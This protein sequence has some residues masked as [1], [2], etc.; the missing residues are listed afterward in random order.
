M[1]KYL[2]IVGIIISVVV[3]YFVF[4]EEEEIEQE[5]VINEQIEEP[6]IIIN[7]VDIK[8]A[9]NKPGVYCVEEDKRVVDVIE[10]AEGLKSTA[11]TSVINLSKK[12]T[13]EMTIIV[14]T[15]TQIKTAIDNIS[16]SKTPT[17]IEIIKEVEK[18]CVCPDVNNDACINDPL[19]DTSSTININTASKE[20]LMTL[21]GIG[22]TKADA[23]ITYR[24]STPFVIIDDLKNVSGIGEST[25]ESL[26]DYITV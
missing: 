6:I 14:Y 5:V 1:K 4:Y 2:I 19:E 13:D 9:I 25:F 12:I 18:E 21:P 24:S 17:I 26:K 10:L 20:Q 8:G 22:E 23:I 7:C 3:L 15:K 11:D 16:K